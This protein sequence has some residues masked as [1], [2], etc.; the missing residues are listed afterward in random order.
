MVAMLNMLFAQAEGEVTRLKASL[1]N[2]EGEV[3]ELKEEAVRL[4]ES[5]TKTESKAAKLR[6]EVARL[7]ELL[8][9]VEEKASFIEHHASK[10]TIQA[11]KAFWKGQDFCR[12]L[13]ESYSDAYAKSIQWHRKK[14][15]KH[16][17]DIHLSILSSGK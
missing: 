17:L 8:T 15:V 12:E 14:V 5:L 4:Q 3:G 1:T 13:L 9:K 2:I 7:Q 16:F 11:I 6:V 10:A